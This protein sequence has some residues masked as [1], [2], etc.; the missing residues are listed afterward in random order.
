MRGCGYHRSAPVAFTGRSSRPTLPNAL[1][2]SGQTGSKM[3]SVVSE[4]T[5]PFDQSTCMPRP[6]E[7]VFWSI[8]LVGSIPTLAIVLVFWPLIDKAFGS[9]GRLLRPV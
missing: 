5:R 1:A 4:P 7:R 3:A 9:V 2:P 6:D 8:G